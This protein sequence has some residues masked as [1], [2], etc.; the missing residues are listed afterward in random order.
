MCVARAVGKCLAGH[1]ED[2]VGQHRVRARL[3]YAGELDVGGEAELRPVF[4]DE[5][6]EPGAQTAGTGRGLLKPEDAGADLDDDPVERVDIAVDPLGGGR[7]APA[8][9]ALQFHAE[10]EEFLN[11]M[12]V[13][14]GGDAV[15]VCRLGHDE[16]VSAGQGELHRHGGMARERKCHQEMRLGQS[17]AGATPAQDQCA[18]DLFPGGQR[19]HDQRAEVSAQHSGGRFALLA[20]DETALASEKRLPGQRAD[21]RR[22]RVQ[23]I[24]GEC[25]ACPGHD[26]LVRAVRYRH[27]SEV[28]LR[29]GCGMFCDQGVGLFRVAGQQQR[30]Q[31]AGHRQ[32]P[33][34][35]LRF[36]EPACVRDGCTGGRGE[37]DGQLLVFCG[38]FA[39]SGPLDEVEVAEDLLADADRDA[40]K[41]G[42]RRMA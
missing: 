3:Q 24:H 16:L 42:H 1:G 10:G 29:S 20:G 32:P 36:G 41:A 31:L 11:D 6:P 13:Q 19:D 35:L 37:R 22:S 18:T 17:R 5:V 28:C 26:H 2:V 33:A 30:R 9:L 27:D 8:G 23:Q 14:V 38:E 34:A 39:A 25:S 40:D 4:V 21:D 12:V 15:V 7:V